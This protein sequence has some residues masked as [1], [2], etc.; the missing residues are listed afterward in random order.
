M[1]LSPVPAT[2]AERVR[3]AVR[4]SDRAVAALTTEFARNGG[5]KTG[6]VIGVRPDSP[7]L[8]AT[9][10]AILADDRVTF[11][12]ADGTADKVRAFVTDRGAWIAERVRV[13]DALDAIDASER[14]DVVI[15]AEP[16]TGTAEA[17]RAVLDKVTARLTEGGVVTVA[18]LAAPGMADGASAE[19]D[20]QTSFYGVGDDLVIR[21]RPPLHI[22]RLRFAAAPLAVAERLRP[23]VR[24]SSVP[25]TRTMNIDSNGVAAAGI[26]LGLAVAA[27]ASGR[28]TAWWLLPALA[29]APVAAFFRDPERDTPDD[30]AAIVAASDGKV[31]SVERIS[32]KRLGDD[33]FLRV[34]VFLSVLDVHVNRSPV[35]G[36]VADYF[37]EDGGFAAA[38]SPAAEHNVAAYTVLDTIHGTVIV[39]Q[40]TGL[41]ARRIVQ[42][43]PVGSML[44]KGE[45]LGLIRFGSRTDVYLPAAA[46][47]ATVVPG[48]KVRG[49][50][51]VIARWR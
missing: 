42:R 39:A 44:A 51:T 34:A 29:A 20:R 23:A 11:V 14:A 49:G 3:T 48:D 26:A 46:S 1:S 15:F 45:R 31:L 35:A 18:T 37:V 4:L 16:V 33:P 10:E 27:K 41:I 32:D 28:R 47:E 38:M 12:A 21:N 13:V 19:L 24:P 17:T 25:L 9:L 2:N 36:R 8:M 7:V 5:P 22:H 6:L 30:E 43:A 50:S 40:R